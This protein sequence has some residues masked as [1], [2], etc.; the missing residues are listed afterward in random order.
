MKVGS[1][2]KTYRE[3]MGLTQ[4]QLAERLFISPQAISRYEKDEVEPNLDMLEKMAEVFECKLDDLIYGQ[5]EEQKEEDKGNDTTNI[6]INDFEGESVN[7]GALTC[8]DCH[9]KIGENEST[10][11][12]F[13]RDNGERTE[14]TICEECYQ[15]GLELDQKIEQV[16]PTKSKS[17]ISSSKFKSKITGVEGHKSL[18][19]GI[20]AA[21]VAFILTLV[22]GIIFGKAVSPGGWVGLAFLF[23]YLVLAVVY[24]I[25]S[26][27]YIT[28]M[29]VD[30]AT[31]SV[32]VPVYF[33]GHLF[34]G[35]VV[36]LIPLKIASGI[37]SAAVGVFIFGIAL[38]LSMICASVSFPFYII[39]R[40]K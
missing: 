36:I 14:V 28:E 15:K 19:G 20:I 2:I 38:A 18:I 31:A 37:I 5:K 12:V 11:K 17:G 7:Y 9:R 16:H 26:D 29:F 39:G 34:D 1:N 32:K 33:V 25:F 21:V 23:A 24:C 8:H 6:V 27:T 13:R 4:K 22:L 3:K 30:I 40:I 10:H 35:D